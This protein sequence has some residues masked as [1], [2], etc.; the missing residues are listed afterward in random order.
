[1]TSHHPSPDL[2][3]AFSAGSLKLSHALCISAHI[4]HCSDCHQSAKHMNLL[5]SKL[6]EALK[7]AKASTDL[8]NNVMAM[9]NSNNTEQHD[10]T[11]EIQ[12]KS[13][14]P[15][16]LTQF[17]PEGE[18]DKLN[19]KHASSAIEVAHLCNDN[20]SRVDLVRI[21]PGGKVPTHTHSGDELTM[22]VDG[23]FSDET[24]IYKKGDFLLRDG[25]HKHKPVAT[26]D[27]A[28]ICLTV[29]DSP[30]VFTGFFTR[31]LNPLVRKC[32]ISTP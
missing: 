17:I 27:K 29:T 15:K 26:K 13:P 4:E 7:P 25:R 22:I 18:F 31:L 20:G 1:M 2:L 14:L 9:L 3:S 32:F 30:I 10:K 11:S 8:K 12:L 5:G 23:S 16:A 28:C 19:W 24:G 6:F 21:K